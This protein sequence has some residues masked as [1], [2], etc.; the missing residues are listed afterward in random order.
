MCARVCVGVRMQGKRGKRREEGKN[1]QPNS[2][3]L[4]FSSCGLMQGLCGL[5]EDRSPEC[6][7]AKDW[8]G[9]GRVLRTKSLLR[10]LYPGRGGQQ[11][12][13]HLQLTWEPAWHRLLV[14]PRSRHSLTHTGALLPLRWQLRCSTVQGK[15]PS[16]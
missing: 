6:G 5:S 4:W 10:K 13:R 11:K 12:G 2:K 16:L 15:F 7:R 3:D 8:V 1:K 9:L 14:Y